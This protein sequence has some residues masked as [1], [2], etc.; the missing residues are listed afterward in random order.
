MSSAE[1]IRI[2]LSATAGDYAS[3]RAQATLYK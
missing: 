3:W 1:L 2:N